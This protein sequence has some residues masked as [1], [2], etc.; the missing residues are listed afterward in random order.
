MG[1]PSRHPIIYAYIDISPQERHDS[2][3]KQQTKKTAL[4]H[5]ANPGLN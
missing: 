2:L 4:S 3:T 5:A 1:E